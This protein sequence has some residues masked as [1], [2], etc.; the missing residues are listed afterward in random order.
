MLVFLHIMDIRSR[1]IYEDVQTLGRYFVQV[2]MLFAII[3]VYVYE[4]PIRIGLQRLL[5][6]RQISENRIR[7]ARQRLLNFR[8]RSRGYFTKGRL[9]PRQ[10]RS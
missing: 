10:I 9:Y 6:N 2:A 3:S 1:P 5:F 8:K 7:K 4:R